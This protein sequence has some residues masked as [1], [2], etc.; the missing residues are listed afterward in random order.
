[1]IIVYPFSIMDQDLALKNARWMNEL[2][3]CKGH[4]VLMIYDRRCNP[5]VV[6]N[7]L[8]ELSKAFDKVYPYEETSEINGWPEGANCFFRIAACRLETKPDTRYFMWMEPDAIPLRR[9]WL[10]EIEKA[11]L[12]AGKPFMGDRVQVENIP[13]HMSGIGIYPL[14]LHAYAG[15]AYRAAEIAFDMA[16][17]D[18]IV[19][20]AHFTE[21]IEHAWKH[22][23]FTMQS[24]LETQIS[25]LAILF[26]SS[27]D[28]S[29]IDLLQGKKGKE[30]PSIAHSTEKEPEE[31]GSPSSSSPLCDIFIRTYPGDYPWLRY[32]LTAINKFASGFR[33]VWV[34]SPSGDS[35][36]AIFDK[37]KVEWR[38]INPET[39][40][41]YLDQQITKLYADVITNYETEFILHID[42]DVIL[43]RPITPESFLTIN[44]PDNGDLQR[45]VVWPHTPYSAIQTPWQP[46][47]EKFM[48]HPVEN[49]FMRRFPIMVPRWLYPRMRE[50]CFKRHGMPL[51]DYI[52]MQPPRAFSEFNALGAYAFTHHHDRI[53]WLNTLEN[54]IPEPFAKQFHSWGGITEP[55]RKEIEQIVSKPVPAASMPEVQK[56]LRQI[57]DDLRETLPAQNIKVLPN[58]I[59]VLE[60]DQ[61]SQWVEQEGRLDHDQN[62]LPKILPHIKD[63]DTVIDVGAFIGDHT[64]AYADAVGKHGLVVAFEPNPMARECLMHNIGDRY[65]VIIREDGLSDRKETVPL[66]G[67]NG[68]WGGAYVG[69]HMKIADVKMVPLDQLEIPANF[70]KIDAEGYEMKVLYGAAKTII[71][72]HPTMVIEV[73]REAL[74]RQAVTPEHIFRWLNE[75]GYTYEILQENCQPD[76]PMY[77]ILCLS[78]L[79]GGTKDS[80][81]VMRGEGGLTR[82]ASPPPPVTLDSSILF[83]QNLAAVSNQSRWEVMFAL[84]KAGLTPRK[85]N[86]PKKKK[87]ENPVPPVP[88]K[89]ETPAAAPSVPPKKG[90]RPG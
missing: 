90:K 14:P 67:N 82:C 85:D 56:F 23:K 44:A 87:H 47:T 83:L 60:G 72:L 51:C 43:T 22:P 27:K 18:Q 1:M 32:A 78:R 86:K 8:A 57:D 84:Y 34:I 3:G 63:G 66:S 16:G 40:D 77:D 13:L 50:F 64:I 55:I 35:V 2:G 65:N 17:K 24:E 81:E 20:K 48:G 5:G 80:P 41:G 15:E 69:D 45:Q 53:A 46:I 73:N 62:F 88:P 52:R 12:D 42:S 7:I 38:Q 29:L 74:R 11:Y 36:T 21:L 89:A 75:V 58:G 71:T 76:S 30:K 49:E 31:P 6:K 26:H 28:G 19:P 10:D 70:I 79:K 54:A 4:E 61:I 39:E 33:K 9:D 68:N 37:R 59:W 25:P